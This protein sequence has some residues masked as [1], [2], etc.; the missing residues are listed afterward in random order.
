MTRYQLNARL[1]RAVRLVTLDANGTFRPPDGTDEF[2]A[3]HLLS[4]TVWRR[5][6]RLRDVRVVKELLVALADTEPDNELLSAVLDE[7][8]QII[9]QLHQMALLSPAI[10]AS[11]DPVEVIAI[12]QETDVAAAHSPRLRP[13]LT[14]QIVIGRAHRGWA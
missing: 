14:W 5:V 11:G 6:F 1:A 4:H 8:S 12:G 7:E 13:I 10:S 2:R 3:A 9:R